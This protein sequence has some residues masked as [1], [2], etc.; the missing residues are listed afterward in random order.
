MGQTREKGKFGL[1]IRSYQAGS[2]YSYSLGVRD[3]YDFKEAMLTNSMFLNFMKENGLEVRNED[4]T[5]DIVCLDFGYGSRS[6]EEEIKH[7]NKILRAI[8]KDQKL[9]EEKRQQRIDSVNR[10]IDEATNNKD[11]FDKKR[12]DQIRTKFYNDGVDIEYYY[13]N[14]KGSPCTFITVLV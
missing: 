7:L 5:R 10:R 13:T 11:K 4:S 12:A 9:D 1:R 14:K 8:K 6:Y 2:V 3:N